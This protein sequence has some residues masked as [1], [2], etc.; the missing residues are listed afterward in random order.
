MRRQFQATP[1][2]QLGMRQMYDAGMSYRVI[3]ESCGVS[4]TTVRK[5]ARIW[6]W[7]PRPRARPVFH[8]AETKS[9]DEPGQADEFTSEF[10]DTRSLARRAEAAVRRQLYEIERRLGNLTESTAEKNARILASL[11]RSLTALRKIEREDAEM[12]KRADGQESGADGQTKPSVD[13]ARLR[14]ELAEDIARQRREGD[15]ARNAADMER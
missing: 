3:A 2:Q 13:L 6:G 12:R 7:S 4:Q 15:A 11:V 1:A 9:A 5:Y 8:T 14:A 10:D